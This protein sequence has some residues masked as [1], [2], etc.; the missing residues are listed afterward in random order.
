MKR[1]EAIIRNTKVEQVR[2]ILEKVSYSGVMISD[3][4]GHGSQKG[5]T[6]LMARGITH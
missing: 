6:E 4:V 5:C 1:I 2:A 3:V